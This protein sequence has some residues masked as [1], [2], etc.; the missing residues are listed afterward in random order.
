MSP[1]MLRTFAF[2]CSFIYDIC[3][4][5]SGKKLDLIISSMNVTT[6]Q[7]IFYK[8]FVM[9]A[10]LQ[11]YYRTATRLTGQSAER[12][13]DHLTNIFGE[14]YN[15]DDVSCKLPMVML[16]N[17]LLQFYEGLLFH[18]LNKTTVAVQKYISIAKLTAC[19]MSNPSEFFRIL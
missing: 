1:A 11:P 3:S 8:N 16:T 10:L 9:L 19:N 14:A 17:S 6:K 5:W 2:G 18:D 12:C 7:M 13:G 4:F 15:E